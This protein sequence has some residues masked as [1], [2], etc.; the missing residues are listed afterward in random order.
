MND[1]STRMH[2]INYDECGECLEQNRSHAKTEMTDVLF[3]NN[4]AYPRSALIGQDALTSRDVTRLNQSARGV[5]FPSP[6]WLRRKVGLCSSSR[7]KRIHSFVWDKFWNISPAKIEDFKILLYGFKPVDFHGTNN[8]IPQKVV[9]FHVF[10]WGASNL[11][12]YIFASS[13]CLKG[14][15][16]P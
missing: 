16:I 9:V 8:S 2:T 6:R 13:I 15:V 11:M 7:R 4:T 10:V 14:T 5:S 3:V 12:F 1:E